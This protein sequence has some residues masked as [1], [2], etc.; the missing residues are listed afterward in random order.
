MAWK[1]T[2]HKITFGISKI[3]MNFFFSKEV[4]IGS[5]NF[6]MVYENSFKLFSILS[7]WKFNKIVD[8]DIL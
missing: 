1:H 6:Y 7:P 2:E 3:D 8:I 4:N 5:S